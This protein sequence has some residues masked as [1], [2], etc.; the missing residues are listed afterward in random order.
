M[1]SGLSRAALLGG[2]IAL[3]LV[4]G[5]TTATA[6]TQPSGQNVSYLGL[7]F[8]VPADWPVIDISASSSTCVRFDRHAVY[9]GTPGTQQICP[10]HLI[11][12]SEAMLV[13]PATNSG[14]SATDNT[15]AQ[16]ITVTTPTAKITATYA[17]D[18]ATVRSVL[19][20]AGLPTAQPVTPKPAQIRA[21][22]AM[23]A[24]TV[25]VD[26]TNGTRQGFDSCQ[27]P[28]PDTMTAWKA[29][30]PYSAVGVYIGGP[31]AACPSQTYLSAAWVAQQYAAGWKFIPIYVGS[32]ALY[33]DLTDPVNQ[34]TQQADDAVSDAQNLGLPAGS[35]LY[36]DMEG[37]SSSV[38]GPALAFESAWVAEVHKDGYFAGI[39]GSA[40]STMSDLVSEA[41]GLST[42]D[43]VYSAN[44]NGQVNTSDPYIPNGYWNPHQRVHQYASPA[45]GETYGGYSVGTDDDYMDVAIA[46]GTVPTVKSSYQSVTPTRLLD[47]RSSSGALGGPGTVNIPLG[48]PSNVTSVVLNVT[49]VDPTANSYL[50]VYP[51][52]VP[53]PGTSSVNFSPGQTIANLV[54]VPVYDGSVNIFNHVGSAQVLA[55]LYGYYTTAAGSQYHQMAPARLLDTR[56]SGSLGSGATVNVTVG[57]VAGI[58]ANV[59]AVIMNLTV[60]NPTANSYLTAYAGQ[61]SLPA[62]SNLNFTPGETI[63]NLAIVP[64]NNGVV[65]IF[66][67]AGTVD[68]L[69]DAFGYFTAGGAPQFTPT[70]PTRVL[71][72]RNGAAIGSGGIQGLRVAGV[73]GIPSNVEAVVLN[74]TVVGPT[75][76][77][78]LTVFPDGQGLPGVSNLNYTAGETIANAVIVPVVDGSID[79]FNHVGSVNALADIA[80]YYTG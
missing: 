74:V 12:S 50:I 73:S 2:A 20:S 43:V 68:V 30:S 59:T 41:G 8:T 70:A 6:S 67:H 4:A 39:Y 77:S 21:H 9:L 31:K 58:P 15:V 40:S 25:P 60:T 61:S 51:D 78:Y 1:S 62:V 32:Q 49:A 55:D 22:T 28:S 75:A 11:G 56:A 38:R 23:A 63:P 16:Q 3:A 17:A 64:V 57:G 79:F 19:A 52:G 71:D 34:G 54:T 46:G 53:V 65:S 45:N 37:Y 27:A 14:T 24:A 72:T 36:D 44:W 69:A 47:T 42:P 48:L 10:G 5:T 29:N 26:A 18:K 33:G 80:G 7:N 76:N 35:V 13:Q 66:N